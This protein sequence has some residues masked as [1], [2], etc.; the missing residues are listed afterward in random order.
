MTNAFSTPITSNVFTTG[1]TGT[2]IAQASGSLVSGGPTSFQFNS[3]VVPISTPAAVPSTKISSSN[4]NVRRSTLQAF[5]EAF[6]TGAATRAITG[7]SSFNTGSAIAAAGSFESAS[8]NVFSTTTRVIVISN[9]TT[10]TNGSTI[11]GQATAA[12]LIVTKPVRERRRMHWPLVRERQHWLSM[13][14]CAYAVLNFILL[15]QSMKTVYFSAYYVIQLWL[16]IQVRLVWSNKYRFLCIAAPLNLLEKRAT[17]GTLTT[18]V[19]SVTLYQG[20]WYITT[21]H[22]RGCMHYKYLYCAAPFVQVFRA[23]HIERA[24]MRAIVIVLAV[25]LGTT[26]VVLT[27]SLGVVLISWCVQ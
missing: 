22:E 18:I 17:T 26:I 6:A 10:A 1:A 20:L 13:P 19:C 25:V 8:S 2:I 24:D 12:A 23:F 16:V 5:T 15:L 27:I 11:F 14:V 21:I 3:E 7:A 9:S 4:S